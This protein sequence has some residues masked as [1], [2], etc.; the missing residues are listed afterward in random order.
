VRTFCAFDRYDFNEPGVFNDALENGIFDSLRNEQVELPQYI[1]NRLM[2]KN[3][4]STKTSKPRFG[5]N[6]LPLYDRE[7]TDLG[8]WY[9]SSVFKK[10]SL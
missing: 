2:Y 7:L 5:K 8:R 4:C 9:L 10:K 6:G 3:V 1:I